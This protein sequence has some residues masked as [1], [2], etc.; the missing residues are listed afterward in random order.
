[1]G[2]AWLMGLAWPMGLAWL[3]R[4]SRKPLSLQRC[5]PYYLSDTPPTWH[6]AT[7][8]QSAST[9]ESTTASGLRGWVTAFA[10]VLIGF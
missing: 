9:L 6:A 5:V 7:G 3:M 8:S 4:P 1:M 10:L 2:L